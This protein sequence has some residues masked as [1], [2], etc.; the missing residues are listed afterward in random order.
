[1]DL[2]PWLG[3][4]LGASQRLHLEPGDHA[5]ASTTSILTGREGGQEFSSPFKFWPSRAHPLSTCSHFH[6]HNPRMGE[7]PSPNEKSTK[8][9]PR[10]PKA[11]SRQARF[12]DTN[13]TN[14]IQVTNASEHAERLRQNSNSNANANPNPGGN[15]SEP[16]AGVDT[17]PTSFPAVG[18]PPETQQQQAQQTQQAQLG[19]GQWFIAANPT[20]SAQ[21][22]SRAVYQLPAGYPHAQPLNPDLH[23]SAAPVNIPLLHLYSHPQNT[24]LYYPIQQHPSINVTMAADYQNATPLPTNPVNYQPPVPD[25]THG[26]M[27][28]VYIP[29]FDGGGPPQQ[30]HAPPGFQVC[31]PSIAHSR[32]PVQ[33]LHWHHYPDPVF[34]FPW[35]PLLL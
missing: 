15:Q 11:P 32:Q 31:P 16:P 22:V 27:N 12:E 5:T 14:N 10:P 1:M 26:P 17:Q 34:L 28:H 2:L 19:P 33:S 29:R 20:Q 4:G 18:L 35:L 30:A 25:T 3:F 9:P 21:S 7:G 8:A 13:D 6:H 24:Y 23:Y